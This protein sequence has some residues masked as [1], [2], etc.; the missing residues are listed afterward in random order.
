MG[1]WNGWRHFGICIWPFGIYLAIFGIWWKFQKFQKKESGKTKSKKKKNVVKTSVALLMGS[2]NNSPSHVGCVYLLL[3][4]YSM[5]NNVIMSVYCPCV[6]MV[7]GSI[8][9]TR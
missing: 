4:Y 5:P 2:L 8:K 7:G 6:W 3:F 9:Q 1:E